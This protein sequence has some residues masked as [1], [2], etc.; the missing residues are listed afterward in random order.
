M[1]F[2]NKINNA[3][4]VILLILIL[5]NGVLDVIWYSLPNNYAILRFLVLGLKSFLILLALYHYT[6]YVI[7]NK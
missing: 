1:E 5:I 4:L 2:N 6:I 7:K 3:I